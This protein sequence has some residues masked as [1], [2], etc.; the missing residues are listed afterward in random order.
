MVW[1]TTTIAGRRN[2]MRVDKVKSRCSLPAIK[3][4]A[5]TVVGRGEKSLR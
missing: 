3:M 2:S 4:K 1:D 5:H